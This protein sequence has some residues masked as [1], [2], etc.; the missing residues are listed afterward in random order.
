MT[1]AQ[2]QRR[3]PVVGVLNFSSRLPSEHPF[4]IAI[5]KR[6]QELGWIEGKTL[7]FEDVYAAGATERLPELAADLVR[8]K[9]D[10]IWAISPPAAVAA[11]R[12]T[13]SI[14]VV[15]VRVAAPLQLGLGESFARPGGNVTGVASNAG[16]EVYLKRLEFLREILPDANRL[17]GIAPGTAIFATVR[18][19]VWQPD[20]DEGI[21]E[22]RKL[23]FE[24]DKHFV[25]KAEDL[26][27][28]FA[29]IAASGAQALLV[30]A[31]PL[32]FGER[33]RI[34]DFANQRRLPSAFIESDF[35]EA[36]GLL[37][38]GSDVLDTML[39]SLSHIDKILRGAKPAELPIEMPS[40]F[41]LVIN[42]KTARMLGLTIPQSVLLRAIRVIE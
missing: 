24:L 28:A 38:Y 35:V 10:V 20:K 25:D 39:Q 15:F 22:A 4:P 27:R 32:I 5:T 2:G 36:G 7:T 13:K 8:K 12:V 1:Q 29:A 19:G 14:P 9:V 6:L 21:P 31:S 11:A 18:G 33:R 3:L 37:S 34:V 42:Q 41:D 16:L 26:D 30:S 40:R 23:G 17:A